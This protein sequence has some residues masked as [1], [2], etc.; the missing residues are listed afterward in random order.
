MVFVLRKKFLEMQVGREEAG[1]FPQDLTM[2]IFS[3]R[4]K[5]NN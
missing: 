2:L 3:C 5:S 4:S 1:S